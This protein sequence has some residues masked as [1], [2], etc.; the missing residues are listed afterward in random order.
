MQDTQRIDKTS[1]AGIYEIPDSHLPLWDDKEL[2][3]VVT[4]K[5]WHELQFSGSC[6]IKVKLKLH[7]P[8]SVCTMKSIDK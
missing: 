8:I 7:R 4:Q 2:C 1:C 6:V 5:R 3:S